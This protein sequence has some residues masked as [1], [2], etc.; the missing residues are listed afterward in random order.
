M[1]CAASWI[2][3]AIPHNGWLFCVSAPKAASALQ[4]LRKVHNGFASSGWQLSRGSAAVV[5]QAGGPEAWTKQWVESEVAKSP[6]VLFTE[7]AGAG[8]AASR[9]ARAALRSAEVR[10]EA[11]DVDL[12]A[13]GSTLD[14]SWPSLIVQHLAAIAEQAGN[15]A[16]AQGEPTLPLLFAGG[17][18]IGGIGTIRDLSESGMLHDLCYGSGAELDSR[19]PD[20]ETNMSWTER[21]GS[22]WLPPKN[23]NGRRWY[24]DEAN[25][26]L[27]EDEFADEARIELNTMY[28]SPSGTGSGSTKGKLSGSGVELMRLDTNLDKPDK[29]GQVHQYPPFTHI[30]MITRPDWGLSSPL[31][32]RNL[33]RMRAVTA[34]EAAR[35]GL[36][37]QQLRWLYAQGST[38]LRDELKKRQ[39]YHEVVT[40]PDVQ[41]L[42][43]ALLEELIKEKKY[44][45]TQNSVT[46]GLVATLTGNELREEVA[47]ETDVPILLCVT[48]RESTHGRAFREQLQAVAK[49][50]LR[51][52][53]VI[54]VDARIY[55]RAAKDHKVVRFPTLIWLQGRTGEELARRHGV[56]SALDLYDKTS[57]VLRQKE[58]E[59]TKVRGALNAP[60]KELRLR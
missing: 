11:V 47:A 15:P 31:T 43:E 42:R 1:A 34:E 59:T 19:A 29:N 35:V 60:G 12:I 44:S 8:A 28:V 58:L 55:P 46:P 54:E 32:S 50:L 49:R 41:S 14:V 18:F 20:V 3:L 16:P 39:C 21:Q 26:E 4:G 37:E 10:F 38:K 36:P 25:M 45:P 6:I 23:I 56:Q 24:Q 40:S 2:V 53:R 22:R 33:A 7:A 9:D 30:N 52:I 27:T 51:A 5:R 17:D 48:D 13:F 57:T